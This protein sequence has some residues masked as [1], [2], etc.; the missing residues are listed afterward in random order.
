MDALEALRT[1][2]SCRRFLDK[3][4]DRAIVE[5]VIDAGRLAAT[6]CNE[7]PWEFVCVTDP[8]MRARIAKFAEHGPFIAD[9]PLCIVVMS[10]EWIFYMED[11]A[12]ATQNILV[13]THAL[14][15]ASCWVAGDKKEWAPALC[16][17]LGAPAG[18]RLISL[19]A[20]GY[21]ARPLICPPKRPLTEVLHWEKFQGR[22]KE[23]GERK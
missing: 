20:V 18:I 9:A 8:A 23:A 17:M 3:P 12:A 16:S 14:G 2:R 10:K 22:G 13:A 21:P 6:A 11:G 15:L 1:R 19:I 4:I 7:Q 5:Q